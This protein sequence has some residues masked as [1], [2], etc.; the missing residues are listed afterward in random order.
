MLLG[1]NYSATMSRV[2]PPEGIPQERINQPRREE[3]LKA[4]EKAE[5]FLNYYGD[6]LPPLRV[7]DFAWDDISK[8]N[9]ARRAVQ[10][11][12]RS[13]PN[14][15]EQPTELYNKI[16]DTIDLGL[17]AFLDGEQHVLLITRP[18]GTLAQPGGF[19]K[20][21]KKPW[22]VM[23][24][25]LEEE[26]VALTAAD[27]NFLAQRL[28]TKAIIGYVGYAVGDPRNR[29]DAEVSTLAAALLLPEK[30]ARKFKAALRKEDTQAQTE[31]GGANNAQWYPV[32][33]VLDQ[34]PKIFS[35]DHHWRMTIIEAAEILRRYS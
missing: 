11:A 4:A 16:N 10:A 6:V 14:R 26:A 28:A 8:A 18:D 32:T 1:Y 29:L 31:G 12:R 15:A 7:I 21:G 27:E 17:F 22:E 23:I 2:Y 25:E 9:N 5:E 24:E 3:I 35:G 19:E 20:E 30:L 33:W 13:L 34:D